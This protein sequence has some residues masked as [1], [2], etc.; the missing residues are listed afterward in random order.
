[1][2]EKSRFP[3]FHLFEYFEIFALNEFARAL[4]NNT[5]PDLPA[6]I[7]QPLTSLTYL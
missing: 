1:M 3:C 2:I 6:S 5:L 7:F 4:F